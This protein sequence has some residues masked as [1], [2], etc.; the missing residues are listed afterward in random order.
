MP[1]SQ[2]APTAGEPIPARRKMLSLLAT[3]CALSLPARVPRSTSVQMKLEF[4]KY[5]G[6]GNDFVLMDC[7]EKGEPALSPGE[8]ATMCDRNFGIG[9]DGVIFVLPPDVPDA[10]FRMRIYN[11]DGSE[12]TKLVA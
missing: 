3:A 8:A 1:C 10:Q 5:Q 2:R 11:S 6:L 4:A 9:A 7:R 12:V